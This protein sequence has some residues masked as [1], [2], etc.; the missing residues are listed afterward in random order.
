VPIADVSSPVGSKSCRAE[1]QRDSK[2][3]SSDVQ[4]E[5]GSQTIDIGSLVYLL[6]IIIIIIIIKNMLCNYVISST[7]S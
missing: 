5:T 6:I 2:E 3:T 4:I 1:G 7:G